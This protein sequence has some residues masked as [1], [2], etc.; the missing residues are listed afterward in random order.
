MLFYRDKLVKIIKQ[1]DL[2]K[3]SIQRKLNVSRPAFWNWEKGKSVPSED[4]IRKLAKILE[5][6]VSEISDL[7][8]KELDQQIFDKIIEQP[9]GNNWLKQ[10]NASYEERTKIQN[11]IIEKIQNT[12]SELAESKMVISALLN[13]MDIIFYIKNHNNRYI[14]ANNNFIDTM[15]LNENY[16]V[17]GKTDIDLMS[18]NDAKKNQAEDDSIIKN[19]KKITYEGVIPNTR[20]KRWAIVTKIPIFNEDDDVYGLAATYMDITERRQLEEKLN[21][22]DASMNQV[23]AVVCI[24]RGG[25]YELHKENFYISDSVEKLY[26]YTK[27]EFYADNHLLRRKIIHEDDVQGYT[28]WLIEKKYSHKYSYRIKTKSGENKWCKSIASEITYQNKKCIVLIVT[29]ITKEKSQDNMLN[30]ARKMF[31]K[32][33]KSD[34]ISEIT[35][36]PKKT[37]I[38]TAHK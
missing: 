29:D 34:V 26:G 6:N 31:A 17:N 5:I 7:K 23:N 25:D 2:K 37:F 38:S 1:K 15:K 8:E 35:G 30:V 10:T 12:Y 3:A 22:L 20:K 33:I 18:A 24:L 32:G 11:S 27:E 13:N 14:T 4:N 36:I 21:V 19:R 28:N 16:N 9:K